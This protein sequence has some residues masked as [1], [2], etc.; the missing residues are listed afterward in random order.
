MINF[1]SSTPIIIIV[2]YLFFNR[3]PSPSPKT[4]GNNKSK[5]SKSSTQNKKRPPVLVPQVCLTQLDLIGGTSESKASSIK[6][7]RRKINN[8]KEDS[9]VESDNSEL[10]KTQMEEKFE[11]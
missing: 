6:R 1:Q 10:D 4:Y 8:D 9:T 3:P 2:Q 11:K 5:T 7:K